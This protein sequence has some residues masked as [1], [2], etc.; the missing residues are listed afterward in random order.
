MEKRRRTI[1]LLVDYLEMPYSGRIV[2]GCIAAAKE[3]DINLIIYPGTSVTYRHTFLEKQNVPERFSG[4]DYF[5]RTIVYEYARK[6]QLDG[7]IIPIVTIGT[8]MTEEEQNQFLDSFNIPVMLLEKKRNGN[9][10]LVFEKN[11]VELTIKH[12]VE[13]CGKTHIAY[14]SG[15]INN[16]DAMDR[17][18]DYRKMMKKYNLNYPEDYIV[19]GDFTQFCQDAIER[20]FAKYYKELDAICVANDSMCIALYQIMKKYGMT[21]GVEIAVTGYDDSDI[22]IHSEPRLTSVKADAEGMGRQAVHKLLKMIDSKTIE[23]ET[24]PIQLK[25]RASTG[26]AEDTDAASCYKLANDS[27]ELAAGINNETSMKNV[28]INSIA[29][30]M[31]EHLHDRTEEL[32]SFTFD[33][34]QAGIEEGYL[35]L[36]EQSFEQSTDAPWML[37]NTHMEEM[38]YNKHLNVERIG[39]AAK[40]DVSELLK[41]VLADGESHILVCYPIR[42][43]E[44]QYGIM[45][46]G[47]ETSF[48][49]DIYSIANQLATALHIS[50]LV[51]K[52]AHA[53]EAKSIF[54]ANMSH[55][56][57]TP[58]N[59]VLGMDE[60]ILRESSESQIREYALDIQ[61]AG[62]NLLSIINDVLDFSKIESGKM[63]LVLGEYDLA[64]R[65]HDIMNMIQIKAQSKGLY[66][67]LE[68]DETLP[69]GLYGDDNRIQQILVNLLNNAVKYTNEG[70]VTLSIGGRV[71][72]DI[73]KLHFEVR[74]TGIGIREEDIDKLFAKFERIE[75]QRNRN[76]EGT[77]LGM[78]IVVYLLNK[79]GSKLCVESEYG[80]GSCF[81][82]DLEQRVVHAE[83]I[84]NLEERL[85]EQ[86]ASYSY[87]AAFVAPDA[88]ILVVDDNEINR[89]VFEQ[90]LK[91]SKVQ[92]DCAESGRVCLEL[93]KQKSYDIIFMDHMMP[94]MDGIETLQQL[95]SLSE[96]K[97]SKA[98]VIA[99]TANAIAGAR[100]VYLAAGFDGYMTKPIV[101]KMLEQIIM[102][103]LPK[104]K[105]QK[106]KTADN[107]E[108]KTSEDLNGDADEATDDEGMK[109]KLERLAKIPE[110]NIKSTQ[111][112]HT[113][114]EFLL[115]LLEDY[116]HMLEPEAAELQQYYDALVEQIGDEDI[117]QW[118]VSQ[119]NE[120]TDIL[121]QYRI[122]VHAMKSSSALVGAL[123]LSGIAL[124]LEKYAAAG[125]VDAVKRLSPAF[126]DEWR[127]YREKLAFF[128]ED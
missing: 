8:E 29:T 124:C 47:Y 125:K 33:I 87:E 85:K 6:D 16:E 7:I 67:K 64:S 20:M 13:E 66:M 54:L 111:L 88:R 28:F 61:A 9:S 97:S 110:M 98:V 71:Q 117:L 75:E 121:Q 99:L 76:V 68:L 44:E 59:A 102:E 123:G 101:P 73:V 41:P 48:K 43:G 4:K 69:A 50:S 56:I 79:M 65:I 24:L 45:Y 122:K 100:E 26:W 53:T 25:R 2:Q 60:M 72:D 109:E 40:R 94:D 52:L 46:L 81:S 107:M 91:A 83:P 74:D 36:Q 18:Q 5:Q 19:Y 35:Y 58:I 89:K 62:K 103:R 32:K 92:V 116:Y 42:L 23:Q 106:K 96:N 114:L 27:Y 113:D 34:Q 90:L 119:E 49:M 77:G 10:S 127:S 17:I 84:G 105:L 118:D 22:A 11:G 14:I 12:L 86:N 55:E 63:E 95:N 70:G 80:K 1:G 38:F 31:L 108:M 104:E 115:E 3:E 78:S 57:R 21:P 51:E 15:P 93:A 120:I 30:D 82:F 128:E 37:P 39:T 126:L 112:Y